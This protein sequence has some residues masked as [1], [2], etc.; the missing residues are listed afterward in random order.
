MNAARTGPCRN[1][2]ALIAISVGRVERLGIHGAADRFDEAWTSGIFKAPIEGPARVIADHLDGDE[3]ADLNNHGGPDKAICAYA[4]NHYD[5]WRST[6]GQSGL[7]YGAFGENFTIEGL[8]ERDVCIGDIWSVGEVHVQVSQ[9]RQPCWKLARKWRIDD[10]VDQVITRGQTGWYFR[11]LR[12]G[13][14][15]RGDA[16]TLIA[17]SH[18]QWTID[19]AN[20]VM[21]HRRGGAGAAEV[22]AGLDTLSTS[23]KRSLLKRVSG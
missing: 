6:F 15:T 9:P 19:A 23:W 1:S 13:T 11:V 4:A 3:Q 18:P 16:L 5:G 10:L 17:R 21:H 7:A 12:E 8:I 14:V 20:A 22:L 2:P